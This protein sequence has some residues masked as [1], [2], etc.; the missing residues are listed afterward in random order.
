MVAT[1]S[2]TLPVF[3][4][5]FR[6]ET[7]LPC[8][9]NFSPGSPTRPSLRMRGSLSKLRGVG[10]SIKYSCVLSLYGSIV[11]GT[12]AASFLF[13][14]STN[15][16]YSIKLS[17]GQWEWGVFLNRHH[18]EPFIALFSSLFSPLSSYFN[19]IFRTRISYTLIHWQANQ[20]WNVEKNVKEKKNCLD[21]LSYVQ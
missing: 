16:P 5:V 14:L 21:A 19:A 2:L 12:T 10:S 3:P 8:R 1:G 17:A 20:T 13:P 7:P 9:E 18:V 6:R 4:V 11:Q 15:R